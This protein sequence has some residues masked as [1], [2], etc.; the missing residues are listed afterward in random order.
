MKCLRLIACAV[1]ML[2]ALAISGC[3]KTPPPVTEAEGIIYL[4]GEPL[5]HAQIQFVPDLK[6]FGVDY[7][8]SGVSDDQG[9]FRLVCAKKAQPGAVV[10]THWVLVTDSPAPDDLRGMDAVTQAKLAEWEASL[11]N[12]PIPRSYASVGTTPLKVEVTKGQKT[13]E[14]KLTRTP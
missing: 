10:A 14:L 4:N 12:R 11:V 5:P 2:T 6:H 3:A 9:K 8:S 7:N 13:Y 1:A